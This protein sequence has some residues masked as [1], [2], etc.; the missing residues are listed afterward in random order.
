[1]SMGIDMLMDMDIAMHGTMDNRCAPR[2]AGKV[3]MREAT[4]KPADR[5][6]HVGGF[7]SF[8]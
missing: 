6:S 2:E 5:L 8:V 4:K 3:N 7:L 1:M